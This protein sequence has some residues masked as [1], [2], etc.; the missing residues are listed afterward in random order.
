MSLQLALAVMKIWST[1]DPNTLFTVL[2]DPFHL[3]QGKNTFCIFLIAVS[4]HYLL[5]NTPELV[6]SLCWQDMRLAWQKRNTAAVR[7]Q[8]MCQHWNSAVFQK[9]ALLLPEDKGFW[10][11]MCCIE[12]ECAALPRKGFH[13]HTLSKQQCWPSSTLPNSKQMLSD[14]C[15]C[16]RRSFFQISQFPLHLHTVP[17][18]DVH[19]M[20]LNNCWLCLYDNSNPRHQHS[21]LYHTIS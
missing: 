8:S 1:K 7:T 19:Y 13:T 10:F 9:A 17:Y 4:M 3:C 20:H 15:P 16:S 14:S 11:Q 2:E 12:G 21:N 6:I 5:L 18:F